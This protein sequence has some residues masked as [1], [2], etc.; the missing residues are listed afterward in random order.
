MNIRF[1]TYTHWDGIE[2]KV[3]EVRSEVPSPR[4]I[5]LLTEDSVSSKAGFQLR[6]D[7]RTYW[8]QILLTE[9]TNAYYIRTIGLYQSVSVQVFPKPNNSSLVVIG[10]SNQAEA[11][12]VGL[13][14]T[15]DNWFTEDVAI[16]EISNL[17]ETYSPTLNLPMPLGLPSIRN[18]TPNNIE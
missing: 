15:L 7:G 2:C 1:G 11:V 5:V 4:E 17:H 14:Q 9:L 8:K 3:E 12:Q 10:T 16:L 18:I 6:A 13:I